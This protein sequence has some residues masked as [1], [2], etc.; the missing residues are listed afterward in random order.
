MLWLPPPVWLGG[1]WSLLCYG[2]SEQH[3][4]GAQFNAGGFITRYAAPLHVDKYSLHP[5]ICYSL[6]LTVPRD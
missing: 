3:S 5:C 4:V 6:Q 2:P 1:L